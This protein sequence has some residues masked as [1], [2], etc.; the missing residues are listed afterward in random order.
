MHELPARFFNGDPM[1]ILC[2]PIML[3]PQQAHP[4]IGSG[5]HIIGTLLFLRDSFHLCL[6]TVEQKI[7]GSA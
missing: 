3:V 2:K 1:I 6:D 7:V 5:V 4:S